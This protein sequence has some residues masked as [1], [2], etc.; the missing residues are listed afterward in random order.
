MS[1]PKLE[2]NPE[3]VLEVINLVDLNE[4]GFIDKEEMA[5]FLK[6]LMVL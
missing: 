4:D 6:V 2:I 3:Q 5:Y 1:Y